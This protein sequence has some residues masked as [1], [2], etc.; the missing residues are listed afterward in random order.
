MKNL[1]LGII[2]TGGAIRN[3]WPVLREL[4]DHYTVAALCDRNAEKAKQTAAELGI[5]ADI[6]QDHQVLL[7]RDDIDVIMVALPI[8]A[9][10]NVVRDAIK[11]NKNVM[12]EKPIADT[13]RVGASLIQAAKQQKIAFMV[14][15]NFRYRAEYQQVH[16]LM[17]DGLIGNP[18]LYRLNDIHFTQMD[19]YFSNSTWRQEGNYRGGYLIEAGVHIVA[20]MDE[21][22]KSRVTH[23]QALTASF[24]PEMLG[25]QDDTLLLNMVYENGMVGQLT[26]GYG[27]IDPDARKPK[28]YGDK[29]TL[30][31]DLESRT[32]KFVSLDKK[33]PPQ[34]FP[35][36]EDD[37][38]KDLRL[39]WLDF[40][41]AVMD[42]KVPYSKPEDA[43]MDLILIDAGIQSAD[44]LQPIEVFPVSHYLEN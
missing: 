7:T 28:V 16:D 3:H 6:Y 8:K 37:V 26:L 36:T 13:I 23:V 11:A 27:A 29:G 33:V 22:V 18:K 40:Y 17:A 10:E 41:D 14:G 20:G 42:G 5:S 2:G 21:V 35:F 38:W 19:R 43:L 24:H 12:L 25:N 15:E 30:V 39:E 34:V 32:I 31:M 44:T 1:K 4:K 9:T